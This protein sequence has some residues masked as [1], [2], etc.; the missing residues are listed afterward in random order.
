MKKVVRFLSFAL[1]LVMAVSM[2]TACGTSNKEGQAGT[3]DQTVQ[4]GTPSQTGQASQ[5]QSTGSDKK[6]EP[7]TLK[8]ASSSIEMQSSEFKKMEELCLANGIKLDAIMMPPPKD[9]E[10]DKLLVSLMSGDEMDIMYQAYPNAKKFYD[11]GVITPLEELTKGTDYNAEKVF[12]KYLP[13]FD[14]KVYGLPTFVDIWLTLYN[15]KIF[16]DA[17]VPYPKAEGWTWSK[18]VETAKK[19]TNTEKG[20]FGSFMANYNNYNYMYA[21]QCGAS[22]YKQDGTSNYDDPF[23]AEGLKFYYDLGNVHKIQPDIVTQLGTKMTNDSFTTGKYGMFVCGGWT[24]SSLMANKEKYPRDWKFGVLPMPYPDGQKKST[25]TV[26]G[27]YFVPTTS[28]HKKEAFEAI[29]LLAEKRYTLGF[30]KVPCRVDLSNE[31]LNNYITNDLIT[32][33]KDDGVTVDDIRAA[34][35]DPNMEV[36]DEK[37][38]GY[39]STNINL[40]FVQEGQLYATGK[41]TLE[42]TMK[43]IKAQS[44][45]AIQEA[46]VK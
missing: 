22:H 39:G 2:F 44:D 23:F 9:G 8:I 32:A 38:I 34:W 31:E 24:L 13:K 14:G 19:L 4:T 28:K 7:V 43:N 20:I 17:G 18:Y 5:Q 46:K 21:V 29:K 30:G 1:V 26:I 11:A 12:G 15:K 37:V 42:E 27:C 10:A 16:D 45:K 36:R 35:F 41:Q 3:P 25:L 6:A 40:T 33:Y